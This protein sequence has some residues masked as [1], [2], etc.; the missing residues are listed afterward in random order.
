MSSPTGSRSGSRASSRAGA[1]SAGRVTPLAQRKEQFAAVELVCDRDLGCKGSPGADGLTSTDWLATLDE[2]RR[3]IETQWAARLSAEQ[4]RVLRM[5]GTEPC[6]SGRYNATTD[7][8]IYHC[9][10]CDAPLYASA[11]KFQSGHGWPAF[12]K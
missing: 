12:A 1:T 7:A 6:D 2:E 5:K 3:E 8:G 10:A 11:H 9:A 4:F